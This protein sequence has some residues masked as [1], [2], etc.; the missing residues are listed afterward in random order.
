MKHLPVMI[1]AILLTFNASAQL[2]R[3]LDKV[4]KKHVIIGEP[5][6][7]LR[8]EMD[9]KILYNNGFGLLETKNGTKIT[10]GTNFRMA[11]I[12]KQFTAMG[13]LLLEQDGKLSTKDRLIKYFPEIPGPVSE[14][15]TLEHLL[16]HSSGIIDY[17]ALMSDS[18]QGQLSD[19]DVLD[20]IKT[21]DS[22]YFEPGTRFRYSN[23]AYC[24]MSLLIEKVSGK[25]FPEF[26]RERIF[27]PLKM[28]NSVVYQA[29]AQITNRAMGYSRNNSGGIIP[30]DQS[31]TS[32]TKGDGGVYTSLNDYARWI[33]G[34]QNHKLINF[35][36]S[37]Q[38]LKFPIAESPGSFYNAGWF[39]KSL[40]PDTLFHSGSTCG[41][42]TFSIQVPSQKLSIVYFS[43][44]AGNE[45]PFVEILY[46]LSR[47]GMGDFSGVMSLHALTR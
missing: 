10:P 47:N 35:P 22:T 25:T 14:K 34:L 9:G 42:S 32:A 8:I 45:Q 31:L 21:Q 27:V 7:A 1:A 2:T 18:I 13:I 26:I 20:M 39:V 43:N 3:D 12:S 46:A 33:D 24:L 30:S 29:N 38:K 11:S 5:G 40:S 17:E 28:N 6:I 44:I 15:V 37:T 36:K 16:S 19:Q 4:F 23:S 41:F